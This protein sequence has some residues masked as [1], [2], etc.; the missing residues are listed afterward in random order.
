MI[1]GPVLR[2]NQL[3]NILC[4]AAESDSI[5]SRVC[6]ALSHIAAPGTE[7]ES[8]L[9]HFLGGQPGS[10]RSKKLSD[11]SAL[12]CTFDLL[13]EIHA[14]CLHSDSLVASLDGF[15]SSICG[16]GDWD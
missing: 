14:A 7:L 13:L 15:C 2:P 3:L 9:K 6:N 4:F 16:V 11:N 12:L 8:A 10:P 1:A 5:S